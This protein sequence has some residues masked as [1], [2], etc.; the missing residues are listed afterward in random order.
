MSKM[1]L[2]FSMV[3]SF[4]AILFLQGCALVGVKQ[5]SRNN[6]NQETIDA[7]IIPC[8]TTEAQVIALYRKPTDDFTRVQGD[9]RIY[10]YKG[11]DGRANIETNTLEVMLNSDDVVV[12]M[13]FNGQDS[14]FMLDRCNNN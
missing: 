7:N 13:R 6:L 12:D 11:F 3:F 10:I 2:K 1:F 4:C 5:L 9:Y 8:Q 14:E